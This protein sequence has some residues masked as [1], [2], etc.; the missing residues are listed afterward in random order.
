MS[1]IGDAGT[2]T[3]QSDRST[4]S[5]LKIYHLFQA[6]NRADGYVSRS[7]LSVCTMAATTRCILLERVEIP[8][9]DASHVAVEV[10]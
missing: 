8:L 10:G 4:A 5:M 1:I 9:T 7:P 2:I 3:L 6:G